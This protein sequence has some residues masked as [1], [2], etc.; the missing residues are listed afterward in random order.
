MRDQDTLPFYTSIGFGISAI[1]PHQRVLVALICFF[2]V[3]LHEAYSSQ[4]LK[5]KARI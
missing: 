1:F 5:K 3:L 4:N 2:L